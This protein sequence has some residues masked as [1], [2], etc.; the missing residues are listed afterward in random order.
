M[1]PTIKNKIKGSRKSLT[2]WLNSTF[3]ALF[4]V[5]EYAK[6]VLPALQE[7]LTPDVYKLVGLLVLLAN[8]F[9]RFRTSECLSDKK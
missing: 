7:F 4:P 9:L 5:I 8:I 1:K 2:V 6:E 3:L